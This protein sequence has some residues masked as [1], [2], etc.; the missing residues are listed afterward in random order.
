MAPAVHLPPGVQQAWRLLCWLAAWAPHSK[1]RLA[2]AVAQLQLLCH[3]PAVGF[4]A[5][6]LALAFPE[7]N[8]RQRQRLLRD[9]LRETAYALLDRFRLWRLTETDLRQQ[10]VLHNAELLHHHR[11]HG[12][13]V[14]LCPHFAGLEAAGQRLSLEGQGMTLYRPQR[15][16]HFDAVCRQSRQRFGQQLLMPVGGSLLPLV[17]K[18]QK[19]IVL[20]IFPDLDCTESA[21]LRSRFLGQPV[22]TSPIA[23]WCAVRLGAALLP[24][25]VLRNGSLYDVTV[26]EALPALG[27]DIAATTDA[28]NAALEKLIRTAPQQY[29]WVQS[30]TSGK[31]A[32]SGA[33]QAS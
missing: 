1:W 24:V 10:V 5:K 14:L 29:L 16:P 33:E 17:R 15:D 28:V 22:A 11:A 18:L 27:E 13:V 9:N 19:G 21:A 8:A 26:H 25:T 3:T 6:R 12:P 2:C 30:A 7:Q 31:A 32:Q 20:L 23:A 4:V